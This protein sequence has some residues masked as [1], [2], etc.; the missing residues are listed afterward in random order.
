MVLK[1]SNGAPGVLKCIKNQ[2][3]TL[4]CRTSYFVVTPER[5]GFCSLNLQ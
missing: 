5:Y 1:I 4:A 3:C 2:S